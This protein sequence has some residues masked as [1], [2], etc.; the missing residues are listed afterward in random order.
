[1]KT[2][3]VC[4]LFAAGCSQAPPLQTAMGNTTATSPAPNPAAEPVAPTPSPEMAASYTPTPAPTALA[5]ATVSREDQAFLREAVSAA[6]AEVE[7]GRLAAR[8]ARNPEV[9]SFA[10]LMVREHSAANA[11]LTQLASRKNV[12][13]PAQLSPEH[14]ETTSNLAQLSG[15]DFDADYLAEM[16][17]DHRKDVESFHRAAESATDPEVKALAEK[18]LPGLQKQLQLVQ[19]M[20]STVGDEVDE[21]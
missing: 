16:L 1:M 14:A 17:A 18:M 7:M 2:L 20:G 13:L 3:L 4:V 5:G 6:M 10:Q 9:K 21:E 12:Q 11:E 19:S 15:E 8:L